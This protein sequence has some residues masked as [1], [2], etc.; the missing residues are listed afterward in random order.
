M[1]VPKIQWAGPGNVPGSW[2]VTRP[3][4]GRGGQYSGK[5][6]LL[7]VVL[8]GGDS[9]RGD[10]PGL[11]EG[12]IKVRSIRVEDG[13]PVSQVEY[14]CQTRDGFLWVG[15]K[16]EGLFRFDGLGFSSTSGDLH[17]GKPYPGD[18]EISAV[19]AGGDGSL[20]IGSP[21][22]LWRK[23]AG[24]WDHFTTSRGLSHDAITALHEDPAGVVWIGT[25]AGL[26]R[27]DGR[28]IRAYSGLEEA[29]DIDISAIA[30][31]RGETYGSGRAPAI[32][33]ACTT[34]DSPRSPG[35]PT[36]A[37]TRSTLSSRVTMGASGSAP[38]DMVWV[39]YNRG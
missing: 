31:D 10:Q 16:H 35:V 28:S 36:R 11:S 1:R 19:L 20:W 9:A 2:R 4:S 21:K 5:I 30:G 24:Q 29:R 6:V 38:G 3:R 27:L 34:G 22:G 33:T 23:S 37:P 15:S 13:L 18:K 39:A 14:L 12:P 25:S 17:T 7:I 8:L 32:S 26:N